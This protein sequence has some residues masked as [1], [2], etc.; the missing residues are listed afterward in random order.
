MDDPPNVD[1]LVSGLVSDSESARKYAVFK[2]QGQCSL[3]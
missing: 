1:T 2:L 3:S